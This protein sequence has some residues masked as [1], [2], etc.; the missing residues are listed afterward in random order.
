MVKKSQKIF[1]KILVNIIL[2][3]KVRGQKQKSIIPY[4]HSAVKQRSYYTN[5]K[6]HIGDKYV[7]AI[8]LKDFYPSVTR[9]KLFLFFKKH[10]NISSD[11][12]MFYSVL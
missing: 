10:F 5:A 2:D 9:Y 7:L 1:N 11:I 8:D 6:A 12:A 4:L 3:E